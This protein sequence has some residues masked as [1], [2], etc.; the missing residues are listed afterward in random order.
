MNM[1]T[2]MIDVGHSLSSCGAR[3]HD[4]N[5]FEYNS[6]IA[7]ALHAELTSRVITSFVTSRPN[8]S[9]ADGVAFINQLDPSLIVSLHCNAYQDEHAKGA[10]ILYWHTSKKSELAASLV[11][12]NLRPI[13]NGL[14]GKH[15]TVAIFNK[16]QRGYLF[17]RSTN[18]P[19][20]IV[21]P[22]FI[23]NQKMNLKMR[24]PVWKTSYV[25][26]LADAV[27]SFLNERFDD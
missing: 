24:S 22:G 23:T 26:A 20:V 17:L 27:E 12:S 13:V 9:I 7:V 11:A 18:A 2:I 15:G 25:N 5:E 6:A 21:E 19:A 16:K 1:K 14:R 3:S 4:L 10:E 8:S